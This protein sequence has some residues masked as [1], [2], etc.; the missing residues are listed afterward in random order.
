KA[1]RAQRRHDLVRAEE[2]GR[3]ASGAGLIEVA[4]QQIEQRTEIGFEAEEVVTVSDGALE[5]NHGVGPDLAPAIAQ[6]GDRELGAGHAI[7]PPAHE[8]LRAFADQRIVPVHGLPQLV[9]ALIR[10][11]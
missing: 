6:P 8:L 7:E 1:P 9:E 2:R 4:A 5:A 3:D 11:V 10:S